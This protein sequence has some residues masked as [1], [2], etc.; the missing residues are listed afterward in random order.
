MRRRKIVEVVLVVVLLVAI[1]A[2]NLAMSFN[3]HERE[4]VVTSVDRVVGNASSKWL[5]LGKDRNGDPIVLQNT[6]NILRLKFNSSD[7]QAA[8]EVGKS[9][10]CDV[11]GYRVRLLS[12]YENVLAMKEIE[13]F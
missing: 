8:I 12:W 10:R 6:D 7:I 3:T 4:I 9:Y 11:I 5:I 13:N 1:I 2:S